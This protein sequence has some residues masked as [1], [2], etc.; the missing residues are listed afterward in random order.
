MNRCLLYEQ[1]M[2]S[3]TL[4]LLFYDSPLNYGL[5]ALVI[6]QRTDGEIL[7]ARDA[8]IKRA[9]PAKARFILTV[10]FILPM[11]FKA[12][13]SLTLKQMFTSISISF[14]YFCTLKV[15]FMGK[16]NERD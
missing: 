12:K 9:E 3:D 16:H 4:F 11:D 1:S 5:S 15:D 2:H 14:P 8:P 7:V 6:L 10:K 13:Y